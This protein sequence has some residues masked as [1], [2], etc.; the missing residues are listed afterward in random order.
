MRLGMIEVVDVLPEHAREAGFVE[1]ND[2]VKT[3]TSQRRSPD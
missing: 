1:H 2:M 3:V